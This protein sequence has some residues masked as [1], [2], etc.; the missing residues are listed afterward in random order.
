MAS[1]KAKPLSLE[2]CRCLLCMEFLIEPITLP[3]N[4]TVCKSCF[5]A[6]LRKTNL[7]CPFCRSLISSWARH[8]IHINSLINKELWGRLQT[9][10]PEECRHRLSGEELSTFVFNDDPPIRR[11]E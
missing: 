3:C 7:S 8:H 6:L 2:D 1:S 4:H 9:Q 10:Y 11:K 5:K